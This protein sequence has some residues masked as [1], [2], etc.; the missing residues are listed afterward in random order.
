MYGQCFR[1]YEIFVDRQRGSAQP[2][3]GRLA[4]HCRE[5]SLVSC[6]QKLQ[7]FGGL[8]PEKLQF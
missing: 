7:V 2:G 4:D 8:M 1:L 6:S 3:I 5:I